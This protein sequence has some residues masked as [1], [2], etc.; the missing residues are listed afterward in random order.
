MPQVIALA[1]LGAGLYAGY[2]WLTRATGEIA[3]QRSAPRKRCARRPRAASRRTWVRWNTIPRAT[4][5]SRRASRSGRHGPRFRQRVAPGRTP[6]R[7]DRDRVAQADR[8]EHR[9]DRRRRRLA[10]AH[11]GRCGLSGAVVRFGRQPV[12][13]A[14]RLPHRGLRRPSHPRRGCRLRHR[15]LLQCARAY[16]P[17]ARIPGR[18]APRAEARRHCRAP[19]ADGVVAAVDAGG[20]LSPAGQGGRRQALG[21]RLGGGAEPADAAAVATAPRVAR[22]GAAGCAACSS[23]SATARSAMP[24]RSSGTSAGIAG[25][26]CS[27]TPAGASFR[28][29]PTAC[30]TP[31]T[32]CSAG[33]S[34][35]PRGGG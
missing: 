31:A 10:G 23:R 26:R 5:I 28:A 7:L 20:A 22:Q 35:W 24:S 32:A 13:R 18:A 3:A 29:A 6:A 30:S 8:L 1:L 33:S 15:L 2:R 27:R 9:R 25:R 16:R 19:V 14:S 34:R 12:Q 21:R 17:R 11:A 4:S